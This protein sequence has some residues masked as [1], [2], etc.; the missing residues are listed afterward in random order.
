MCTLNQGQIGLYDELLKA[1]AQFKLVFQGSGLAQAKKRARS[2]FSR[3]GFSALKTVT[4]RLPRAER[5]WC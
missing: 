5:F 4:W 2:T 3:A 1:W